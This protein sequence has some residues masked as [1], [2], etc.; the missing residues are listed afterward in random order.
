V[1]SCS[2]CQYHSNRDEAIYIPLTGL[3]KT[4]KVNRNAIETDSRRMVMDD[5]MG[6]EVKWSLS[7][8]GGMLIETWRGSSGHISELYGHRL[9]ARHYLGTKGTNAPVPPNKD[10]LEHN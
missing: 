4:P 1:V 8:L 6:I 5:V 10:M 3:A 9:R 7:R 2:K